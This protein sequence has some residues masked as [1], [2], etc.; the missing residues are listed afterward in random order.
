MA[1][2]DPITTTD[3]WDLKADPG[4]LEVLAGTWRALGTKVGS[5]EGL[6]NDAAHTVFAKEHWTG[7]TAKS[8]NDYRKKFTADVERF[9]AWAVNVAELLGYTATVLRVQQGLLD[10]ER[11]KLAAVPTTTDL[12]G[13][14][15]RPRDAKESSLVAGAISTAQEIRGRVDEVLAEKK[16]DMAFYENQLELIAK[17]WKPRTVRMLNLNIGQGAGNSPGDSA[18]TDSEDISSIAQVVADQG[19]DIAT[20]QEVFRHDIANL[21]EELEN[22]TGDNWDVRFEEASKKYHANDDWPIIG[23]IINA[24]FGNAVLVREGDVIEGTGDSERVKLDVEG[25]SITV[26]ANQPGGGDSRIDDGEGRSAA[27]T[28]VQIRPR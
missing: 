15:F 25:G 20:V 16:R 8:F 10:D 18:G 4:R 13:L 3:L 9:G 14:T 6:I 28:E 12:T 26:P 7:D 24:P 27:R 11:K 22:R 17:E 5:V 2:P 21:E 1:Q 19:A 23:D